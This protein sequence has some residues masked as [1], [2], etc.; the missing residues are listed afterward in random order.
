MSRRR[1]ATTAVCL[2][3]QPRGVLDFTIPTLQGV[4]ADL[5]KH[6]NVTLKIGG[7]AGRGAGR[8]FTGGEPSVSPRQSPTGV[9][10][11]SRSPTS[12]AS[13]V[14]VKYDGQGQP[15][16]VEI[17]PDALAQGEAAVSGAVAEAAKKAQ[18]EALTKMKT[19]MMDMQKDIA[20]SL[21]A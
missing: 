7:K 13:Q 21:Q 1:Q 9:T 6:V 11:S 12:P 16:A 5:E 15:T 10:G 19:I 3:G 20:K 2:I 4:L 18:G 8:F 14:T 17:A